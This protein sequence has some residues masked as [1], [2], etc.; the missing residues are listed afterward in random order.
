MRWDKN[1]IKTWKKKLEKKIY[2]QW[3]SLSHSLF[4]SVKLKKR[5][6]KKKKIYSTKVWMNEWS[7]L[8]VCVCV[9]VWKGEIWLFLLVVLL[10]RVVDK[11]ESEE[12]NWTTTSVW[13]RRV[14]SVQTKLEF[15]PCRRRFPL[16][17]E[18]DELRRR[19]RRR[20]WRVRSYS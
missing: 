5:T 1:E 12:M 13:R 11:Y 10:T 15:V 19:W 7:V 17:L 4:C 3:L 9:F 8:C 20:S 16:L 2:I 18:V 6:K 14:V